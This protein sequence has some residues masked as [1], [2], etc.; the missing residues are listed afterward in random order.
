MIPYGRQQITQ[1]DIELV[2][3]V[4][5]SDFV[6][7]GPFVDKFEKKICKITGAN[8]TVAV[9]SAT[10]ALHIACESLG[11]CSGEWLCIR[12]PPRPSRRVPGPVPVHQ[13][14]ARTIG[15]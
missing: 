3:K 14:R 12:P 6:T 5:K 13:T 10:S 11:L 2:T 4:L 1:K 7:Q 15:P 8:Y 9:N